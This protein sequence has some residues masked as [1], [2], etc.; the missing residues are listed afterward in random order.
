MLRSFAP[1][2]N[3]SFDFEWSDEDEYGRPVQGRQTVRYGVSNVYAGVYQITSSGFASV[4]NGTAITGDRARGEIFLQQDSARTIGVWDQRTSGDG[5]GG[6]SLSVHHAYDPVARSLI[7]WR[8]HPCRA[9]PRSV[10]QRLL[11]PSGRLIGRANS[12]TSLP[13]AA[14]WRPTRIR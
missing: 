9:L 5:L 3:Q 1:L 10:P 4:G 11:V 12:S 2:P 14:M 13:T 7:S 8:W 6:W